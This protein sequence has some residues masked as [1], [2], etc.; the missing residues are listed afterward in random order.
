ML[1]VEKSKEKIL[2]LEKKGEKGKEKKRR[3][4]LNTPKFKF[5]LLFQ[6]L[7]DFTPH[8]KRNMEKNICKAAKVLMKKMLYYKNY[9]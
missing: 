8:F 3:K 1:K 2:S 4:K 5:R 6:N 7:V 9:I